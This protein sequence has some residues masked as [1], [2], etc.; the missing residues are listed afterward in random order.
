MRILRCMSLLFILSACQHSIGQSEHVKQI[1]PVLQYADS[2]LLTKPGVVMVR[3]SGRM[4]NK[5]K[6]ELPGEDDYDTVLDDDVFYM[7]E[8]EHFLDSL[9]IYKIQR[10]S[11]GVMNFRAQNGKMYTLKLDSMFFDVILFNGKDEPIH[12]D[13]TDLPDDFKTYMNK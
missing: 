8:S 10:E 12:G 4:I 1:A 13:I 9:K 6:K 2:I 5:M 7:S 3:P 11:E